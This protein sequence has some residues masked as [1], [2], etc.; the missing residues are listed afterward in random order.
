MFNSD[1]YIERNAEKWAEVY[2]RFTRE[3]I[4]DVAIIGDMGFIFDVDGF[5][6]EC[7]TLVNDSVLSR[8]SRE[9]LAGYTCVDADELSIR[10]L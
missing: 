8:G 6:G 2:N 4:C 5:I 9:V 7:F 10:Y 3:Y 1:K